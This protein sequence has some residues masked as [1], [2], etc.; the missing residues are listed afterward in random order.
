MGPT[1]TTGDVS[2]DWSSTTKSITEITAVD[3]TS[4]ILDNTIYY[5]V[6]KD[7]LG[8][9]N[10]T[11]ISDK[12]YLS[13]YGLSTVTGTEVDSDNENKVING[14]IDD[15]NDEDADGTVYYIYAFDGAGNL[16]TEEVTVSKVDTTAPMVAVTYDD[17]YAAENDTTY[18]YYYTGEEGSYE[19]VTLTYT[20]AN[21][22]EKTANTHPDI[23]VNDN[24]TS[25][26]VTELDAEPSGTGMSEGVY[27]YWD[28]TVAG[29][30]TATLY[31]VYGSKTDASYTIATSYEDVVGNKLIV[32]DNDS[33]SKAESGTVSA[34]YTLV[35]D[36]SAPEV[37]FDYGTYDGKTFTSVSAGTTI[38][39]GDTSYNCYNSSDIYMQ[40]TVTDTNIKWSEVEAL[41]KSL[42]GT[43]IDG[44]ELSDTAAGS[45]IS[46]LS[47][48][49]YADQIKSGELVLY[50][51]L[52]TDA[53][54]S[55]A[56]AAIKDISGN[57]SDDI[58]AQYICVDTVMPND[59]AYIFVTYET[60]VVKTVTDIATFYD[61]TGGTAASILFG[62]SDA[63]VKLY[64]KDNLSGVGSFTW[65]YGDM[66]DTVSVTTAPEVI[67]DAQ[68]ASSDSSDNGYYTAFELSLPDAAA[69]SPYQ[70][71]DN[72]TITEITDRAGNV[73]TEDTT[74]VAYD[75]DVEVILDG[76]APTVSASYTTAAEASDTQSGK[77][78]YMQTG[79]EEWET[80]VLT[81]TEKYYKESGETPVIEVFK[82]GEKTTVNTLTAEPADGDAL[83]AVSVYWT[84]YDTENNT[85][86]ATVYLPY[87]SDGAE[88]IYVVQTAYQ[89][90]AENDMVVTAGSD[91]LTADSSS[92]A[93]PSVYE[94][95]MLVL[96]N[97]APT[98]SFEYG[99]LENGGTFTAVDAN[100]DSVTYDGVTY[101]CYNRSDIYM[102]LTVVDSNIKWSEVTA[103]LQTLG[104]TDLAAAAVSAEADTVVDALTEETYQDQIA[105]GT[106]EIYVP[107][108]T[109]AYYALT[110]ATITDIA[111][112][113]SAETENQYICVDVTE[114]Y[115]N[116]QI[117]VAYKSDLDTTGSAI[118]Q[119]APE[120]FRGSAGVGSGTIAEVLFGQNQIEVMLYLK[121]NMSGIAGFTYSY[122]GLEGPIFTDEAVD[123]RNTEPEKYTIN[124]EDGYYT[125]YT[126]TV[127]DADAA[128]QQAADNLTISDITD[129]AGNVLEESST[130][131]SYDSDVELILDEI[132]P[133]VAVT[134][135]ST[136]ASDAAIDGVTYRFYRQGEDTEKAY[137]TVTLV[138]TEQ[139]YQKQMENGE[140]ILPDISV[141]MKDCKDGAEQT[142]SA[143]ALT[144][145]SPDSVSSPS[146]YWEYGD[147]TMTAYLYLP[148]GSETEMEYIVSTDYADGSENVLT[149]PEDDGFSSITEEGVYTSNTL[150]LDNRAPEITAFTI[151]DVSDKLASDGSVAYEKVSSSTATLVWE[152]DDNE[153][154]WNA[155][156]VV[157]T[158]YNKTTG[159]SEVI[160]GSAITWEHKAD[161]R[162][163]EATYADFSGFAN[164]EPSTYYVTV[165][166]ADRAQN[167]LSAGGEIDDS[168]V[169]DGTYTSD[170]FILD[171]VAPEFTISYSDAYQI[172]GA[173]GKTLISTSAASGYRVYYGAG[174]GQIDVTIT[175]T[176]HYAVTESDGSLQDFVLT[177]T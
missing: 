134:Y 71:A 156:S 56:A 60:D 137:E 55:I 49:D 98:V 144:A 132:A 28:D 42:A 146:V 114:P 108:S 115:D 88:D 20:E 52:A 24:D 91:T 79:T 151:S 103:L 131:V 175:V 83:D 59:S 39:N 11:S 152:M 66:T 147:A 101:S 164:A 97:V 167:A 112:N 78:Y 43:G 110:A 57:Q 142:V 92:A 13:T 96:D 95:A 65:S 140:I 127:T 125:V 21:C 136:D 150:V 45:A 81:Y 19:T 85:I 177:V 18:T 105:G 118:D 89:D 15:S 162:T 123:L 159:A 17:F 143:A 107:L 74:V 84:E 30:M 1:I 155:D 3:D 87:D 40:L 165:A 61:K 129:K 135:P 111:G 173:D 31:F 63:T 122:T 48:E 22:A 170:T 37:A 35:L 38:T 149:R 158:I 102:K 68:G 121:D 139:Y 176:E 62:K 94:T 53:Y 16:T 29:T 10:V 36:N 2:T 90:G 117:Y 46:E 27:V 157:F 93:S 14:S 166:Y 8:E 41:V 148:Y 50:I 116:T 145:K 86:T 26:T 67:T 44:N 75:G 47:E 141:A 161:S 163:Y 32:D 34:A 109:E 7:I 58:D 73:L 5:Y 138:Y 128:V 104:G 169:S 72:L 171:Q 172:V 33:T 99:T 25:V 76:V 100:T 77:Y 113:T 174:E 54:Y 64:L 130:A 106:L 70:I 51:P 120:L 126:F 154:Y 6:G 153:T 82:N 12:T 23:T 124:G 69:V 4:G 9:N 160:D 80:V 119:I 168:Y 133:E